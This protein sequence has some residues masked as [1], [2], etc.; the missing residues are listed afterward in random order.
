MKTRAGELDQSIV[1]KR[2]TLTD[3][4]MGGSTEAWA[5]FATVFARVR[6]STGN[7][8]QQAERIQADARYSFVIRNR[9]DVLMTDKIYFGGADYNITSI[10]SEGR[11]ALFL[12]IAAERGGAQ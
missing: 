6:A 11:R 4:G 2:L 9:S 12:E 1:I 8:S 10:N 5:D 3:D 7:E